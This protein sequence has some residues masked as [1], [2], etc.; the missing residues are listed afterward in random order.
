MTT[1]EIQAVE[2]VIIAA[3]K[4][5]IVTILSC[6]SWQGD[7]IG[8]VIAQTT[9]T[10]CAWVIYKGGSHEFKAIMGTSASHNRRMTF[11]IILI[12]TDL[13]GRKE[14]SRVAYPF[15][16]QL[17]TLFT[18]KSLSPLRGFLWPVKDDLL[19]VDNGKYVY[20]LEFERRFTA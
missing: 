16:E 3:I 19:V 2:D 15:I 4:A 8:D 9:Q 18:G 13:W 17:N 14:G 6:A 7:N 1:T 5:N 12:V 10:P 11:Q 20:S